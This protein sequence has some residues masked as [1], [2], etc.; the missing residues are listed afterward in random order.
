MKK[1]IIIFISI[2]LVGCST[3]KY[4]SYSYGEIREAAK[5]VD[6]SDGIDEDEAILLALQ[7]ILD[8]SLARRL[9]SL[10]PFKIEEK[11]IWKKDGQDVII[12]GRPSLTFKGDIQK[13]WI[14]YFKDKDYSLL[15]GLIPTIPFY[16][17]VNGNT[18]EIMDYG[19][20]GD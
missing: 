5:Y 15:W 2:L 4:Q 12:A 8:K 18:G 14:V 10:E 7:L 16:V 13:R 1:V 11:N 9:L 3:F 17:T 19:L 6:A 20:Q